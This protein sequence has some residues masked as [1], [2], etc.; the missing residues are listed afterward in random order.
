MRLRAVTCLSIFLLFLLSTAYRVL[1]FNGPALKAHYRVLPQARKYICL[2]SIYHVP[3]PERAKGMKK[4]RFL[5]EVAQSS[6]GF[7]HLKKQK[8][9]HK[10]KVLHWQF[11]KC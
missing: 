1:H 9:K 3:G 11:S 8:N 7:R 10:K 5:T 4:A 2:L 6:R